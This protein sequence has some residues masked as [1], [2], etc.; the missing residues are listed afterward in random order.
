MY[1]L[2]KQ[3]YLTKIA[4]VALASSHVLKQRA[5]LK[6][7]KIRDKDSIWR[8]ADTFPETLGNYAVNA[9][10]NG[11]I[12]STLIGAGL[13]GGLGYYL[14]RND[15]KKGRLLAAL[16]GAGIGGFGL[17]GANQVRKAY[18][19]AKNDATIVNILDHR[20]IVGGGN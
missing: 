20:D 14:N 11:D 3:A 18:N 8:R 9:W 19:E 17:L 13:G 5:L 15:S 4:T 1:N 6:Q 16:S 10:K 12:A 7:A 2:E